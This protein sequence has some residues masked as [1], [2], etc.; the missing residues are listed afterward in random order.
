MVIS[1]KNF[2]KEKV[3]LS[4]NTTPKELWI[5]DKSR[6]LVLLMKQTKELG[7]NQEET[8][9]LIKRKKANKPRVVANKEPETIETN[10]A[11][12]IDERKQTTKN[13]IP[14]HKPEK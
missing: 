13:K 6:E 10:A 2:G 11:S 7:L 3:Y 14:G 5:M 8:L 1:Q 9:R 4:K 12:Q